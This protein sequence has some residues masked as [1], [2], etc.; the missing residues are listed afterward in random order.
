MHGQCAMKYNVELVFGAEGYYPF[1]Q[2]LVSDNK[3]K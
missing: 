1:S 3:V 2:H